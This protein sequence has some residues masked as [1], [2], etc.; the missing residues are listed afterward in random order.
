MLRRSP[1]VA[2]GRPVDHLDA[3][4]PRAIERCR[5][6]GFRPQAA[7]G[8]HRVEKRQCD[9]G[10][11]TAQHRTAMNVFAGKKRHAR[12][13]LARGTA[14]AVPYGASYVASRYRCAASVDTSAAFIRNAGLL[15][16]PITNA[17]SR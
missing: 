8:H 16:T 6:G 5:A 9:G 3:H 1:C 4:E 2:A 12:Y 7:R 13:L 17:D 15:T 11:E 10:A 14:K